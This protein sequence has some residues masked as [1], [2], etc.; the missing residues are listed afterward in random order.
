MFKVNNKD[1]RTTPGRHS[2]VFIVN[3]EH[4][5]YI[6]LV[7]L[8]LN[9][10]MRTGHVQSIF[11]FYYYTFQSLHFVHFLYTLKMVSG[12]RPKY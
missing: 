2:G 6:F 5:S 7:F 10:Q 3:F 8:T 4:I 11:Y 12:K 9:M 1:T